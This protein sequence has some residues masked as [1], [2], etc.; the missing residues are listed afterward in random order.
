MFRAV[1][2]N[3]ES[4]ENQSKTSQ[5][6]RPALAVTKLFVMYDNVQHYMARLRQYTTQFFIQYPK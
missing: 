1:N 6:D 4:A 3:T 2:T 5:K